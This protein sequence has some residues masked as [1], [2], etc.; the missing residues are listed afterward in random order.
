ASH[1]RFAVNGS[2]QGN[3]ALAL[4]V[5]RPGER[6]AVSRTVHKSLFAGVLLAGLEAVWMR[7][8]L[9]PATGLT[10]G[11]P[12]GEPPPGLE[13]GGEA[14]LLVEPAY[15]GAISNLP[16]LA[17]LAH[18]AGVPLIVDQAWGAH[19]GFHPDLPRN[20]LQCGADAMVV[21]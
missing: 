2:T 7:P 15:T 17:A 5:A 21:S 3:Q 4:A 14:V 18:D 9:D 20:A 16:A 13:P 12:A 6:V 8:D 10:A 11:M 1:C 19:L